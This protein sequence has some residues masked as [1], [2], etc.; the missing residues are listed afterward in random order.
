MESD[1]CGESRILYRCCV[2]KEGGEWWTLQDVVSFFY[3]D[4]G[5]SDNSIMGFSR[6]ANSMYGM[7]FYLLDAMIRKPAFRTGG[8]YWENSDGDLTAH[9]QY[10]ELSCVDQGVHI[11]QALAHEADLSILVS[12]KLKSIMYITIS[13]LAS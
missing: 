9:V 12:I 2:F 4:V 3:F 13:H 6:I 11:L 8:L 5:L 1:S 7:F 10:L